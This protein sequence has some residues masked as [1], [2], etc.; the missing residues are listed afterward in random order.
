VL[1]VDLGAAVD[2]DEEIVANELGEIA[3]RGPFA[4]DIG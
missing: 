2:V 1:V 3:G 4:E